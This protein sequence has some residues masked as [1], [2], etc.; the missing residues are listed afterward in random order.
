MSPATAPPAAVET[1][2]A[3]RAGVDVAD[4]CV[5][6]LT[7]AAALVFVTVGMGRPIWAD[8]ADTV[9]MASRGFAG[10]FAALRND[11][12]FPA[13]HVLLSLSIRAFGDSEPALRSLAAV[14]YLGTAGAVFA[15]ARSVYRD[16]RAALF[17][18]LLCIGSAQA[19]SQ[20]QSVR[21]YA[22]LA[23]LSVV[24]L[25]L[26]VRIFVKGE[27][28]PRL[29]CAYLAVNSLGAL[30]QAW[31]AF[32]LLAQLLALSC[33]GRGL[34]SR[35][36]KVRRLRGRARDRLWSAVGIHVSRADPQRLHALAAIVPLVV[37]AG[38]ATGLL[39]QFRSGDSFPAFLHHPAAAH[40]GR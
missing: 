24:S 26:F 25:L 2:L 13:Y 21:P 35:I 17:A 11:N 38:C 7:V 1:K 3:G 29:Y 34:A 8:D 40:R 33:A 10:L 9:R 12:N 36:K 23:F 14:F 4:V 22:M 28:T 16:F 32:V 18:A 15:L 30:T 5:A 20:A 6:A 19:I 39:R 37:L 27:Q 31:F